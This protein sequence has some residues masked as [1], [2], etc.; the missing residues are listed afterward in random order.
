MK[1]QDLIVKKLCQI[2]EEAFPEQLDLTNGVW[3]VRL[4]N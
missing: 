4:Q 3:E 1:A 2:F